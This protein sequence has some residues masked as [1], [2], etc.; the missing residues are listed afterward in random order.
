MQSWRKGGERKEKGSQ[1][2]TKDWKNSL[3][4]ERNRIQSSG[5][6]VH[7]GKK[8]KVYIQEKKHI[9]MKRK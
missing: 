1:R 4:V 6:A 9:M 5:E 8:G 3:E 7:I 2:K